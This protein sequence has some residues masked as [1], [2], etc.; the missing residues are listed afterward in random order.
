MLSITQGAVKDYNLDL[1]S[2]GT[3][4]GKV[5]RISESYELYLPSAIY[6]EL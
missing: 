1:N 5:L 3:I 2:F 4:T 6:G